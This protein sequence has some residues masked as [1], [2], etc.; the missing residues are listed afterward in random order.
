MPL[1][2]F[3]VCLRPI[4]RWTGANSLA[5]QPRKWLRGLPWPG[6]VLAVFGK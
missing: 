2:T 4:D 5:K 3:F 6:V 1:L